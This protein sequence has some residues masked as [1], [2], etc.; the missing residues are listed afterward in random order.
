MNVGVIAVRTAKTVWILVCV[1]D[2]R[3]NHSPHF[4]PPPPTTSH[5]ATTLHAISSFDI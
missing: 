5:A 2:C 4:P 3:L 1:V